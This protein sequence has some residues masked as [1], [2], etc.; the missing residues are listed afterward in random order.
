MTNP[1]LSGHGR[2]WAILLVQPLPTNIHIH[3]DVQHL[4]EEFKFFLKEIPE[5]CW[6][7]KIKGW[8]SKEKDNYITF[9]R[10]LPGDIVNLY[11]HMFEDTRNNDVVYIGLYDDQGNRWRDQCLIVWD[12]TK[13]DRTNPG[14][15]PG[16]L[17]ESLNDSS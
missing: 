12:K 17:P 10:N 9:Y 16:R 15:A 11:L 2:N 1:I 5:S 13:C 4:S 8:W 6:L 7:Q 3:V 14:Y